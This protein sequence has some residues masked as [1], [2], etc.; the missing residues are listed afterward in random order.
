MIH[1][2]CYNGRMS[3]IGINE[4]ALICGLCSVLVILPLAIAL[5]AN[6]GAKHR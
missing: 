4:L 5:A 6:R 1:G 2:C 3:P